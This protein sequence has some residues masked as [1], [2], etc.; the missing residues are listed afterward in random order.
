MK[1][2]LGEIILARKAYD[3]PSNIKCINFLNIARQYEGLS[4]TY[5]YQSL[6][7]SMLVELHVAAVKCS[8]HSTEM[9]GVETWASFD[10]YPLLYHL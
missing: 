8:C 1:Q 3:A 9:K 4:G 2:I 5:Q 10:C 7:M 6:K